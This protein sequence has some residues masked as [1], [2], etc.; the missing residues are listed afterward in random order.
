MI[1]STLLEMEK[2]LVLLKPSTAQ[3]MVPNLKKNVFFKEL[4]F[5]EEPLA[6]LVPLFHCLYCAK[7][8]FTDRA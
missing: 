3:F 5:I 7:Q 1:S 8:T 6:K 4:Y 2:G